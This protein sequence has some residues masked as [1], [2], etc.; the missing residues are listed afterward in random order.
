ME[1]VTRGI[2]LSAIT[3]SI[4][5]TPLPCYMTTA[6][7]QETPAATAGQESAASWDAQ[8]RALAQKHQ[9][10]QALDAANKAVE[11][12]PDNSE[13]LRTRI[14][15]E[16]W[17]GRYTEAER[18]LKTLLARGEDPKQLKRLAMVQSWAN[19]LDASSETFDG[20][21]A[22]APNDTDALLNHARIE[23]WRGDY[24]KALA[25]LDQFRA[26]GGDETVY[27]EETAII[28]AWADRPDSSLAVS[29]GQVE[30]HPESTKFLFGEAV[31]LSRGQRYEESF[32]RYDEL[33]AKRPDGSDVKELG[34]VLRTPFRPY[35]RGDVDYTHDSDTID[36]VFSQVGGGYHFGYD[37]EVTAGFRDH[38]LHADIGS[39]LERADGGEN[40]N[41]TEPYV[42]ISHVLLPSLKL[43]GEIGVAT[44]SNS[45]GT[46]MTYK[47]EAAWRPVETLRVNVR[48]DRRFH[49][50]S[51]R[52]VSLNITREETALGIT[53]TPDL[54]W[55]LEAGGAYASFSDGNDRTGG[56][57]AARRAVLRTQEVNLDLGLSANIS[58]FE[59][60]LNNGYYDPDLLENYAALAYIY[61]KIDDDNGIS[62]VL[63]A[64]AQRDDDMSGYNFAG[65]AIVH[66]YFGIFEDWLLEVK[67]GVSRGL[68]DQGSGYTAGTAGLSLTRRF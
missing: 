19:E 63:S 48:H 4:A 10:D 49:D 66:G 54:L 26:S 34:R 67:G 55:T 3:L 9:L 15:I 2:A 53:Y 22:V 28:L 14:D 46:E 65:N 7:A 1:K 41:I 45:G 32:Q 13:Y 64:G 43:G 21:H 6:L 37:T 20:Y 40:I 68:S 25:L 47:V 56:Y 8:A 16:V 51:P 39:G 57:V 23:S 59:H 12:A 17:D 60:D 27:R 42:G 61:R 62:L 50:V 35:V 29:A 18:D 30:A 11:M 33:V 36:K 44:A 52:A 5:A 38:W 24:P 58:G 31:A